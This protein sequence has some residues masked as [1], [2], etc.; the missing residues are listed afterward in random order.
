MTLLAPAPIRQLSL[1]WDDEPRALA[2]HLDEWTTGSAVSAGIAELA[3]ES[4]KGSHQVLGFLNPA[5]LGRNLGY[6]TKPVQNARTYYARQ[7]E[8]G[9]LASGHA[10]LEGGVLVPVTFKPDKPRLG[11]DGKQIKYER[12]VNSA[13]VPFFAPLDAAAYEAIAA[14]ADLTPP[15]FTSSWS[16]WCWLLE[17]SSVELLVDEG[18]KKSAAACS[19]GYLTIGL[20]GIWNGCPKPKDTNGQSFGAPALI[21]EL[22]WLR[23]IRPAGAPLTIAFDASDKARGRVAIRQARCRLGWLLLEH[24]HQVRI[25]EMVQPAGADFIK[26][27]DDLLVHGGA[28]A[29]AALPVV[30]FKQWIEA[31]SKKA[32]TD[33]LLQ[34]FK[35]TSRKHQTIA[36]HFKTSDLPSSDLVAVVGGMAS[37]KTGA[38]AGLT[39]RL[40]SITHRRS[41]ADNQGQ[42]FGLAVKREGQ[43]L[44]ALE[45][46]QA[47]LRK[48]EHLIA[49]HDG[50]VVVVDSSYIGGSSELQ[51]NQCA[52]AVL[53]IDEADAFLRH[54]LMASTHIA[55]HRTDALTNLAACVSAAQQVVLAGAHIDE[56][57]LLA[58]E[59][60]RGNG[61]KAHIIES[62]LQPAAGRD[63]VM[64][65]K[66]EDLLQQMRNLA[67]NRKP[68]IFH[69]GSKQDESKMAPVNLA[70]LVRRYWPTA[71]ILEMTA[72]TIRDP[73]HPAMAAIENPQQLLAFDVVLASPVL[74]TG[75]SIEDLH[76]HFAAVLGHTSG[77]TLPQAFVQS[78][79]RLRSPVPR[80]IW[81]NHT[82][83]RLGNGAPVTDQLE[84]GKLDHAEAL[85]RLHL[86]D[87]GE[88]YGDAGRYLRWWSELAANQNWLAPHYRHA[89]A[90]LLGRE[91]YEVQR[92]DLIGSD[93]GTE[94]ADELTEARDETVAIETAAIAAAPAPDA[95]QLELLEGRQRLTIAQRRQIERGRIAR[96][97][98]IKAPTAKQVAAS[99]NGSYGKALLHLLVVDTDAR[100]QWQQQTLKSL[101]KSQR[102][103]APDT[104][105]EMAPATRATALQQM[106]WLIELI[107]LAGTGRTVI[108]ANFEQH[109]EAAKAQS[110]NWREIFG[111]DPSSGTVRTFIAQMLAM[112]GFKLQRTSRREHAGERVWWHYEVI[113]ELA[114]LDRQ[115]VLT[116]IRETLQ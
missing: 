33:H 80:H 42:R 51:P 7:I 34:P 23:E 37:N 111:F 74:E 82:G 31:S 93:T 46:S 78:L 58:F 57:T 28:D 104:C 48:L 32:I 17:Q 96:D 35:T 38:I 66:V 105:R 30:P 18:E 112:L 1:G 87:A 108:G 83:S 116:T 25:R 6:A 40:V 70:R 12:P 90:E 79:G 77:H 10:P 109:H 4:L 99:R 67:S 115:Q 3:V 36:R 52:G 39:N 55:K 19:H 61:A 81:C 24:G 54:C 44:H 22:Q 27:T 103:Y 14:R 75:F 16:A 68:F 94:L 8:G 9:W 72:E 43:M 47:D 62:T 60:M 73:N 113:D 65:R 88:A 91:G 53:F 85:A 114:V 92:L 5:K 41:L 45:Q 64:H 101:S 49:E 84:R 29:L 59:T 102:A 11:S 50:F 69:T 86:V 97:F 71:Q 76:Q 2:H 56:I 13:P 98:G 100:N 106:P 63:V 15:P 95:N 20:A 110:R 89:V 21:A 107:D 26:G